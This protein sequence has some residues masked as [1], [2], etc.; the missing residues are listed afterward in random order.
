MPWLV[1][2]V[3][4]LA[5]TVSFVDRQILTLMVGPIRKT[6]GISDTQLSML[7]GL[8]FAIFYTTLGIPIGRLI[9]RHR[10]TS[11]IAAGIVLW[12]VMT[13]LCGLARDF[14]QL[15]LARVGVGIGEAALSPGA[16]SILSDYFPPRELGRALNIYQ[17]AAYVGAGGATIAGGALIALIPAQ[18]IPGIGRLEPWQMVFLAIGLPGLLVALL[19]RMLRKPPRHGLVEGT[20]PSLGQV[21]RHMGRHRTS[22]VLVIAGYTAFGIIWNG[23]LAWIPSVFIRRFGWTPA[24][25]GLRY[26]LALMIG[27]MVGA[28]FGGSVIAWL[29]AR[30]DDANILIGLCSLA[31]A[32]P[33]LAAAMMATDGAWAIGFIAVFLFGASLPWGG[34]A[35]ALQEIT[36]NQMRGQV[37]AIYLFCLSLCGLGFGPMIAASFTDRLFHDD[38]SVN[39]SLLLM[40]VILTPISAVLLWLSRRPYR[41]T[42]SHVPF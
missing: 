12:S 28:I 13:S 3:L 36:P 24:E 5:Y 2:A 20:H 37:S 6:L 8:A 4:V 30:Y 21:F 35:A 9:D 23:A 1:T 29:R 31:V 22:Y 42:L 32:A 15:F 7:H 40:V 33:A 17:G 41:A 27:G 26:G 34:V 39:L 10:R 19:V 38:A 25:V 11:I 16:F 18:T 14:G